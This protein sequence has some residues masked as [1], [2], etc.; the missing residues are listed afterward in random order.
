M[1]SDKKHISIHVDE[2]T[3]RKIKLYAV[4]QGKKIKDIFMEYI[5]KIIS[6]QK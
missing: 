4:S 3:H 2:E 5:D 6:E 1:S